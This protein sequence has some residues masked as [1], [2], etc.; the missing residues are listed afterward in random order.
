MAPPPPPRPAW[1]GLPPTTSALPWRRISGSPACCPRSAT[2]SRPLPSTSTPSWSSRALIIGA[3]NLATTAEIAAT[4]T[5]RMKLVQA[6]EAM[7]EHQ[8]QAAERQEAHSKAAAEKIEAALRLLTTQVNTSSKQEIELRTQIKEGQAEVVKAAQQLNTTREQLEKNATDALTKL[9]E[10]QTKARDAIVKAT[11]ASLRKLMDKADPTSAP[12]LITGIMDKAASDMRTTTSK[13]SDGLVKDLTKQ[14]GESSPLVEKIART[15]REGAEAEIKHATEQVEKLRAELLEQ[16]TRTEHSPALRGDSY[17]EDLVELVNHGAAVYG[18]TVERTG[19]E[20]GGVAGSKKGDHLIS[21][22]DGMGVAAI[23]ARARKGVSARA[24]YDGLR[25]TAKNRGTKIVLYFARNSDELPSGLGE[26]SRGRLPL[27]YKRARRRRARAHHGHRSG[28][29]KR[30]RAPRTHAVARPPAARPAARARYPGG[31]GDAD[32]RGVAVGPADRQP[33]RDV[34]LDQGRAHEVQRRNRQGAHQG[35]RARTDPRRGTRDPRAGAVGRPGRRR[36]ARGRIT[37]DSPARADWLSSPPARGRRWPTRSAK[38]ASVREA[39]AITALRRDCDS[40]LCREPG[41][42]YGEQGAR[43][44]RLGLAA[45]GRQSG[46]PNSERGCRRE[47][48]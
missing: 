35:G 32:R 30:G 14:F 38:A 25:D 21:D 10:A 36:R 2:C 48:G 33:A 39:G 23:E 40:R 18:W 22:E 29:R 24:F 16:R 6:V 46:S 12:A 44:G 7:L 27:H 9:T 4:D 13:N 15:V 1:Q 42:R 45:R 5:A 31:R 8:E 20:I 47:Q 43:P 34:H 37:P 26:F 41:E 28:V 19:N 17:E 3:T 11:E